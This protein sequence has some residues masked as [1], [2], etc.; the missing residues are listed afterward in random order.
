VARPARILR[1]VLL[2]GAA[3]AAS[4]AHADDTSAL[5]EYL[6]NLRS[7]S[8]R[9]EQQRFDETGE[10]LETATGDCSIE[11]PGRFR[12]N[13]R[14]PYQQV[15]VSD[16]VKLWIYDEDLAQVTVNQVTADAPGTPAELLSAQF[17]LAT[18]YTV[19]HLGTLQAYDWYRL[20]PKDAKSQ[21]Q[22]VELGFA[23]REIKAMRLKDN[24]GQSTLLHFEDVKRN[25]P[26]AQTLFQ[27]TPPAGVD[28]VEGGAP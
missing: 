26:M 24:L 20:H 3:F 18:R 8:A 17:D 14:D 10:L 6:K 13:Y 16:S 25:A 1:I 4:A 27:F 2:M 28:V 19:T 15:I 12:W 5:T 11:R 7:Y 22:E 23:D 9:F 21:F